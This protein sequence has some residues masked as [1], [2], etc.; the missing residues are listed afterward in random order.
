MRN[1][2]IF[3]LFI[4][5]ILVTSQNIPP[6]RRIHTSLVGNPTGMN[7]AHAVNALTRLCVWSKDGQFTS[8]LWIYSHGQQ[9]DVFPAGRNGRHVKC[10]DIPRG[11]VMHNFKI[12]K[13]SSRNIITFLSYK[14]GNQ[15]FKFGNPPP[16]TVTF[17]NVG[18]LVG[19]KGN[20]N[21]G[22][23]SAMLLIIDQPIGN[24][25]ILSIEYY[26]ER[27]RFNPEPKQ[28]KQ[29]VI[30]NRQNSP[31]RFRRTETQELISKKHFTSSWGIK[32]GL[33]VKIKAGFPFIANKEVKISAE[34]NYNEETGKSTEYKTKE[35][36][37]ISTTIKP[38]HRL[39]V[40]ISTVE[41][42][43]LKVP[44]VAKCRIRYGNEFQNL[45]I[46]GE[47][48]GVTYQRVEAVLRQNRIN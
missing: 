35:E 15:E 28:L 45:T 44:Y 31:T 2:V 8:L 43:D 10:H 17:N 39:Q 16:S 14:I 23:V 30:T 7:Y 26:P 42:K 38:R 21:N 46:R 11:A 13:S 25:E 22:Y 37:E 18:F 4:F 34:S 19:L 12:G 36:W 1:V 29:Y 47:Y 32:A 9:I 24:I 3:L 40:T 27:A 20:H 33:S 5:C 6:I 41:T 48:E